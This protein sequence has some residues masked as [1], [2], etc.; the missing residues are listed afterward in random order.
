M[1]PAVGDSRPTVGQLAG[2][3]AS[4]PVGIGLIS[5]G[6]LFFGLAADD[7][8]HGAGWSKVEP[9]ASVGLVLLVIGALTSVFAWR[10]VKQ[11]HRVAHVGRPWR[12]RSSQ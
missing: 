2:R 3:S 10:H 7:M 9:I 1:S 11:L 8:F 12:G 6:L 5:L 4:V